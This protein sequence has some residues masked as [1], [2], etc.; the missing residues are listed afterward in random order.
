MATETATAEKK[1]PNEVLAILTGKVIEKLEKGIVPWRVSWVDAGIPENLISGNAYRGIN[2][3]LLASLGYQRNIFL[4]SKQLKEIGGTL[5]PDERPHM[6]GY[7]SN[8]RKDTSNAATIPEEASGT[9]TP[10][11]LR[12]YTVFNIG[13]CSLPTD[14]TVPPVVLEIDPIQEL[15]EIKSRDQKGAYYDPFKDFINMPKDA[16]FA[17]K[18]DRCETHFHELM[19]CTGHHSR[20]N[21]RI[22]SRCR[23]MGTM[24]SHMRNWWQK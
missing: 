1:A 8:D 11:K 22:S 2:R 5:I 17:S 19:H 13:Q 12:Y 14:R 20:L 21:R 4:T 15:A 16:F 18:E 24:R 3:I 10:M 9:R 23:S 7:L 6:V